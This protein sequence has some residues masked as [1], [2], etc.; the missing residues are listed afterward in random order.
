MSGWSWVNTPGEK[1]AQE[2]G[3]RRSFSHCRGHG[4]ERRER[5]Q[6]LCSI[7]HRIGRMGEFAP[8]VRRAS[9]CASLLRKRDTAPLSLCDRQLPKAAWL[10]RNIQRHGRELICADARPEGPIW[11]VMDR[12]RGAAREILLFGLG[13][14]SASD[15]KRTFCRSV[16]PRPGVIRWE[17]TWISTSRSRGA[18][19][20]SS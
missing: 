4:D 17:A 18:V 7:P 10:K 20:A 11:F 16:L 15:P 12:E 1:D 5:L 14:V 6:L 19:G 13:L 8:P 3:D 9:G 2:A